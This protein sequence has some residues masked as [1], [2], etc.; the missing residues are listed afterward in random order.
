MTG[1]NEIQLNQMHRVS[2]KLFIHYRRVT[3][4]AIRQQTKAEDFLLKKLIPKDVWESL[5]TG[6]RIRFGMCVALMVREKQLPLQRV[7]KRYKYPVK[8]RCLF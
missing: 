4:L 5:S 1:R 7:T 2:R 6:E 8:Y 3:K